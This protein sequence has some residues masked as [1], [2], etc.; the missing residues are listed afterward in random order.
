MLRMDH[1]SDHDKLQRVNGIENYG[2][3]DRSRYVVGAGR[4]GHLV[5]CTQEA[6]A[7]R[8]GGGL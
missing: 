5:G 1:R 7:P 8:N 2:E 6:M 4:C 3:R